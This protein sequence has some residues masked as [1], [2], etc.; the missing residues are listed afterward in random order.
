MRASG[1]NPPR[2]SVSN[3]RG[4]EKKAAQREALRNA[5]KGDAREDVK[6]S[7]SRVS[8]SRKNLP[9][10]NYVNNNSN[11]LNWS[12]ARHGARADLNFHFQLSSSLR[13][14][15]NWRNA[16]QGRNAP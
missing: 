13:D 9:L 10:S 4:G 5:P 15:L 7:D 11:V 16:Q 14:V 2:F 8:G 6:T 12:K 1:L 3:A